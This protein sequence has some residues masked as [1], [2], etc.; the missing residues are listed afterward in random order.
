MFI[1]TKKE[2]TKKLGFTLVEVLISFFILSIVLMGLMGVM[3]LTTQGIVQARDRERAMMIALSEMERL[4]GLSFTELAAYSTPQVIPINNNN[5]KTKTISA[6]IAPSP[7]LSAEIKVV[8]SWEKG[9][10]NQAR[11]YEYTREISRFA[12][13]N[14]GEGKDIDG[15]KF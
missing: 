5:Y 1:Q 11:T 8:V 7:A 4:E 6:R 3:L 10:T 14:S 12:S 13:E 2:K 9:A 15:N